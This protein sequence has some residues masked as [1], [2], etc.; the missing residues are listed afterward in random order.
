MS[1]ESA[2]I[3]RDLPKAT[4][5]DLI[6]RTTV[7]HK[8]LNEVWH[9]ALANEFNST[10]ANGMVKN[11]WPQDKNWQ[12]LFIDDLRFVI[13]A[14]KLKPDLLT[15]ASKN[16]ALLPENLTTLGPAF[17]L[18][19][20]LAGLGTNPN[21]STNAEKLSKPD[22]IG[23]P[24]KTKAW[25]RGKGIDTGFAALEKL[26]QK[27]ERKKSYQINI[28]DYQKQLETLSNE[29]LELL[30]NYSAIAYMFVTSRWYQEVAKK[31]DADIAQKIEKLVWLDLEAAEYDLDI[32]LQAIQEKGTSVE[33]LLKGFQFAPGEVGILNV[34]FN[35]INENHGILTHKTCPATDRF[36][37][38]DDSR[39]KHSCKICILGMP[40]SGE[41]LDKDIKCKALKLPPRK[42]ANDIACQWEYVYLKEG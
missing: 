22:W 3:A 12:S 26:W 4:I 15:F 1:F 27:T 6:Q 25:L 24:N 19:V 35:L 21:T 32:G 37:H 14:G 41:M 40:I 5:L 17:Q 29:Q 13:A 8:N 34:D 18:L 7:A 11:I 31:F 36:E 2:K 38:Y 10:I 28:D 33:S 39:L 20:S 16:T 42:D 23:S 30:W 9:K